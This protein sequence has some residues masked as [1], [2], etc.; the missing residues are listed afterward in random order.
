MFLCNALS[1]FFF[2]VSCFV[3]SLCRMQVTSLNQCSHLHFTPP[4]LLSATSPAFYPTASHTPFTPLIHTT[5]SLLTVHT[6]LFTP[7]FHTSV[8]NVSYF[9]CLLPN[10]FSHSFHT[11]YSQHFF[12]SSLFTPSYS[13]HTIHTYI[14]HLHDCVVVVVVDAWSGGGGGGTGVVR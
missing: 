3:N 6:I 4:W 14:S 9:S 7:T 13:H 11:S 8:T 10:C 2:P 5:F 12:H 1:S